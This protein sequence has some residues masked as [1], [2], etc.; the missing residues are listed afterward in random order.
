MA[1][2][3]FFIDLCGKEGLIVGGG[4][5]AA[6]K[7]HKLLP[8][9]AALTVVAPK[10]D[11]ELLT[12][13]SVRC[14]ER[15]FRDCDIEGKQFVIAATDDEGLNGS[16]S[17]LCKERGIL[18][19]VVDDKEKC[20]FLFPSIVKEGSLTVGIST[21][22]AS[23]QIAA[24]LRSRIA[25]E[26]PEQTEEILIYLQEIREMAKKQISDQKARASFLK[27]TALLCMEKNRP[28][29][30]EE[31]ENLISSA[32]HGKGAVIL[33]GAGCGSYD[34]ITVRGLNA[35]RSAE[36]LVYDDL[37]DSRLLEHAPESCEK[38]YVGKRS[39]V[40]SFKQEEINRLL[41]QKAEE[42]KRVVRLKGGDPFVFGRGGEEILA[43]KAKGIEVSEVPGITSSIAI[44]AA[45]GIP[46]TH[47]NVSRSFHV[48]TGHTMDSE[49]G[50][51]VNLAVMAQ[52]DGTSIYLMGFHHLEQIAKKLI[53]Y[54][55]DENTPAAV[56]HGGFDGSVQTVR[57]TLATIAGKVKESDIDMPAVIIIGGTAGMEL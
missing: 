7:V 21:G 2:F 12:N 29:T 10:I 15:E 54:G 33:V 30:K 57:G 8:F 53:A 55:K 18:V 40:H 28:L 52:L 9:G 48:I 23:P 22:G 34:L 26:L 27:E 19:N 24:S 16:I 31:T 17:T 11:K 35:V 14:E 3:P 4:V 5:V 38:I 36:V 45:A 1:Y 25:E 13:P 44:P 41:I 42:G 20:G 6:H 37:M 32:T 39:G 49:D 51:P 50:L 56:V 46:V 47:R 43:L